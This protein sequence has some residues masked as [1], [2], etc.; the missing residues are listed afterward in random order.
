[1]WHVL[2]R[3]DKAGWLGDI[4]V[5]YVVNLRYKYWYEN[6]MSASV[7]STQLLEVNLFMNSMFEI[8][9]SRCWDGIAASTWHLY[10]DVAMLLPDI[11]VRIWKRNVCLCD[12]TPVTG[13]RLV[14]EINV[15]LTEI[16]NSPCWDDIAV[17]QHPPIC[18][19]GN[20]CHVML[21]RVPQHFLWL[22]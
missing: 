15:D 11:Y 12:I 21:L 5:M 16:T 22:K 14:H 17:L 1:M 9:N 2:E 3:W 4:F 20:A 7:T 13:S 19:F 8:K 6:K 10:V 18:G